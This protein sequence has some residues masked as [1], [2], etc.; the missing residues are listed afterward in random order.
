VTDE[1]PWPLLANLLSDTRA[2]GYERISLSGGEPLLYRR[3]D[4]LLYRAGSLGFTRTLTTNGMPPNKRRLAKLVGQI[5]LIAISLDGTPE[6]HNRMRAHPQAFDAM[7]ANISALRESGMP[8]GFIFTLPQ[9]NLDEVL[10]VARFAVEQGASLL[11]IHPLEEVGRAACMMT[12]SRPD[13]QEAAF[14]FLLVEKLKAATAGQLT[15]QLDLAHQ[16]HLSERPDAIYADLPSFPTDDATL[17][18]L[19]RQLV[20]ETELVRLYQFSMAFLAS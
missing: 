11:Q 9:H 18:S 5:E 10:W 15:I 14:T 19:I 12:D 4:E 2:E 17:A 6:S 7:A 16:R 13:D 1:T 3:L 8:F 20:V